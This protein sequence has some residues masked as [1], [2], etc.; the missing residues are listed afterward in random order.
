MFKKA[1]SILLVFVLSCGGFG[2]IGFAAEN[3]TNSNSVD[4]SP[5]DVSPIVNEAVFDLSSLGVIEGDENGNMNLSS[6][7]TRAE[8]AKVAVNLTGADEGIASY[9]GNSKLYDVPNDYWG[10][11]YIGYAIDRGI[12]SGDGDGY[13]R[14]EANITLAECIKTLVNIMGYEV[15]A[16][17]KGGYPEGYYNVARSKHIMDSVTGRET[18]SAVRRDIVVLVYNALDV[19]N[20]VINYY[21]EAEY[22]EDTKETILTIIEKAKNLYSQTGIV[23]AYLTTWLKAPIEA[24][25]K[26]QVE[27]D[28]TI[29][30]SN[31][32]NLGKYIGQEVRIYYKQTDNM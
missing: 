1:C 30:D 3:D 18:D 12:M 26:N 7:M 25:E 2:S 29:Y 6:H 15:V 4:V 10:R 23:T 32:E 22:R 31:I 9:S 27:I 19:P 17:E 24:L 14:P 8:F 11:G 5:I 16:K 13:F 21:S 20:L 28:G